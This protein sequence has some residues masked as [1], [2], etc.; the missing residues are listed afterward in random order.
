MDVAAPLRTRRFTLLLVL[1]FAGPAVS[2]FVGCS[3]YGDKSNSESVRFLLDAAP[4]NLDP[5]IGA[6][7]YSEHIHG[8]VFS[9]LVA[10]DAQMNITPDLAESWEIPDPLTYVF[11]LRHGVKFHDGRALTSADVKYTFDTILEGPL[12]TPKRG[13]LKTVAS[14]EAPDAF[15]VVFHLREPY[16]SLLWTLSA[17][18]IG[19]VPNQCGADFAQHPVGTGPFKF[20]SYRVDE[21]L[22][23][24]R[25][26]DYFGAAPKF[27]NLHMRIVTDALV[28]AL[29]LRKGTG[30]TTINSLTPD[31]V[32]TLAK[33]KGLASDEQPGTSL[34]YLA[35]NLDDPVLGKREVRQALAFATDRATI[36]RY[37]LRG[38]AQPAASLLPPNHWAFDK[39]VPQYDFD[40]PRAEALL[41]QSGFKRGADGVRLHLTLKT[42]TDESTRLMSEAIADQWKNVG[43]ALELRPLEFATLYTDITRGTFQ[44]YSLRWVG[45]NNDPDIFEYVFS[46]AKFPPVGANRGHYKNPELDILLNQARVEM[47]REKRKGLLFQIQKIVATDEPYINLWYVDNVCV[48]RDR[49]TNISM[50]PDGSYDFLATLS[51]KP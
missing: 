23:L 38:Q 14:V 34:A 11:H 32:V 31:M 4:T 33:E 13:S 3:S 51:V 37:L 1:F 7:A 24:E 49:L 50:S 9:S 26:V 12:K 10:H 17:P 45:A 43:V 5:R 29:E 15:T 19:I 41:D 16:A 35:F 8:L 39:D 20:V 25:N 47:D 40:P 6:D 28:R 30:D 22:D 27:R 36:I 44:I 21:E 2:M 42:S 18:G 46:S 48:H